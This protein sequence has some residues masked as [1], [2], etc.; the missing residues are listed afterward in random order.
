MGGAPAEGAAQTIDAIYD[1]PYQAHSPLEPTNCTAD[2]R[3]DR[4]EIWAPTQDPQT[5]RLMASGAAGLPTDAITLH[6]TLLGG[7]FGRRLRPDEVAEAVAISK[8]AGAPV[9]L[10]YTR[11]DELRHSF[12]RPA[13]HHRMRAEI[14][15]DG[16]VLSWRHAFASH[17]SSG[18][19]RFGTRPPYRLSSRAEGTITPGPL[20][21]GPWRGVDLSQNVFVI[22]AFFDEVAA[23]AGRDPLELRRALI[24]DERLRAVLDAAAERAGWG[25]P[26]PAGR[27][28][29]VAVCLYNGTRVAQI[30]EVT[31]ADGQATVDRVICAVDCGLPVSPSGVEA[32]MESAVAWSLTATLK[33]AITVAGGAVEQ[34]NFDSY[35]LLR[36]DEMPLVEVVIVP[37]GE[38][39]YG[40]GEP[41][42]PALPAAVLNAIF[43]ASGRRLRRLPVRPEDLA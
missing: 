7:G 43:A 6:V 14:G 5:A 27:G 38:A 25:E 4:A 29:G 15:A 33:G 40:L 11:E 3:A 13:S 8:A 2:V 12:Y 23:A 41:P 16:A 18:D 34:A 22:E 9:Q 20:R 19:V 35:P 1:L 17:W 31:V 26:L 37:S 24:E 36:H 10:L 42:V 30:A 32:Q 28:R 21:V 39:P